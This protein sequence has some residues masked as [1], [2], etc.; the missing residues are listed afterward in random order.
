MLSSYL[1][2]LKIHG[3]IGGNPFFW[4]MSLEQSLPDTF[5]P[6]L[7]ASGCVLTPQVRRTDPLSEMESASERH[8]DV[9]GGAVL[10]SS[11]MVTGIGVEE[12]R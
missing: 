2:L 9:L 5:A 10:P 6:E 12:T 3:L 4:S 1:V 7:P 11:R 8:R